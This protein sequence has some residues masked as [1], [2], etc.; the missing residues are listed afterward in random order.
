MPGANWFA[1]S[2]ICVLRKEL[3]TCSKHSPAWVGPIRSC[4]LWATDH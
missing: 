1:L 2:G 3:S 4:A